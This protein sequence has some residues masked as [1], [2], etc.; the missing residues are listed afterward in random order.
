MKDER[1]DEKGVSVSY[2]C[3]EMVKNFNKRYTN[4]QKKHTST[5][6]HGIS[7]ATADWIKKMS[8]SLI[9]MKIRMIGIWKLKAKP[10]SNWSRNT[11]YFSS[12]IE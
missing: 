8:S 1:N 11:P 7:F 9:P 2:A 10:G 6:K 5:S 3:I 12:E 4:I